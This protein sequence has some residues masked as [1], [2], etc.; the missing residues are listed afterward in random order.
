M[1]TDAAAPE[2][3]PFETGP[4][5]RLESWLWRI[6]PLWLAVGLFTLALAVY[7]AS[8]PVRTDRTFWS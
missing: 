5:A 4:G 7:L 1:S 3:P 6:D 2:A 8:N